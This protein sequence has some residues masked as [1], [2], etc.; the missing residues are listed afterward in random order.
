MQFN[1]DADGTRVELP[2]KNIDTGA[3]LERILPILQGHDSVFETDLFAPIIEAA[4][5]PRR[6][7]RTAVMSGPMW[8]SG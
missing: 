6:H 7:R 8:R 2:K 1:R 5:L 4:V 3:G